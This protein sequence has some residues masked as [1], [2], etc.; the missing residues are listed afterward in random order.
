VYHLPGAQVA[1]LKVVLENGANPAFVDLTIAVV[2]QLVANLLNV[3]LLFIHALDTATVFGAA[4]SPKG[5]EI[6]VVTVTCFPLI[7][8]VLVGDPVTVIVEAV[9]NL[10]TGTR[11]GV[12]FHR[13]AIHA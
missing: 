1:V 8:E 3:L 2:V 13:R 5:A 10:G 4:P 6:E 11:E 7:G 12:A 9:A